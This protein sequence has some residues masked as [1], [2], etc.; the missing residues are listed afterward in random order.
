MSD[1]WG[2]AKLVLEG[3]QEITRWKEYTV[4]SNFLTPTDGWSFTFGTET[5]WTKL[6]ELLAPERKFELY[7][8]DAIQATG[9]IDRRSAR[10]SID[11]GTIV[12]VQGRDVLAPLCKANIHPSTRL[13]GL[14]VAQ[15]VQSAIEQV[16]GPIEET[17]G[18]P[19]P[20]VIYDN[21][22][23]VQLLQDSTEGNGG[24]NKHSA[25]LKRVLD[26][27]SAQP[28]EGAFEFCA[29]LLRRNGLWLWAGADG[30]IVVSSPNYDQR[31]SIFLS[32]RAGDK[33]IQ[34]Q[35]AEDTWDRGNIPSVV[36][37]HGQGGGKQWE[38]HHVFGT[39]VD[40]NSRV[41][42]PS[43][44]ARNEVTTTQEA[45]NWAVQE[46]SRLKQ[47]ER[48]YEVTCKGHRDPYSQNVYAVDCVAKVD[49]AFLGVSEDMWILERTFTKSESA[50]TQTRM[51]LV[52]LGA[53]QFSD[54]DA[55]K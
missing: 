53:I 12:N 10:C 34:I 28:Q 15:I 21:A 30:Q 14:T 46:L 36:H 55:P 6:K 41:H 23:N 8:D 18:F 2:T 54:A 25:N 47:E 4:T 1:N 13:K 26:Y 9:W 49:D 42:C 22:A 32:R 51:K 40:P 38:Y 24:R 44:I 16:Y 27:Y 31:A 37:C 7:I 19:V 45:Q 39:A 50:G 33:L 11:G 43:Y 3:G 29:R 5:Q 52:P 35:E 48:V 17:L 20:N